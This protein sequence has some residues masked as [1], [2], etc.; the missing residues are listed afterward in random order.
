M[1]RL[2]FLTSA[3]VLITVGL[4]LLST[5]SG[6][7]PARAALADS[8]NDSKLDVTTC[9]ELFTELVNSS[10][11]YEIVPTG[12]TL[13]C[14]GVTQ[15]PI[16]GFT[17]SLDGNGATITDINI[18]CASNNCGIFESLVGT[19]SISNLTLVGPTIASTAALVGVVAGTA[20]TSS[21]TVS[22]D[23]VTV[24]NANVSGTLGVGGLVGGC[25]S[26]LLTSVAASGSVSGTGERVGGIA[27]SM[28]TSTTNYTNKISDSA[29]S[30][31]VSGSNYV[32][33]FVGKM[34]R[35]S[36][37]LSD[38][39]FRSIFSGSAT[40]SGTNGYIGG[41][42]G[43]TSG[44]G[45]AFENLISTGSVTGEELV[46]GIIGW[47]RSSA[48][49]I[50]RSYST[51][52]LTQTDPV[53]SSGAGG[54]VSNNDS[55]GKMTIEQSFSLASIVGACRTG[56]LVGQNRAEIIDSFFRGQLSRAAGSTD[57]TFG[58]VMGRGG[59]GSTVTRTYAAVSAPQS[60]GEGVSG[61]ASYPP[62]CTSTYWDK[63]T[64]TR[65]SSR[66]A[67]TGKT[68]AEMK[69]QTTF[70]NWDFTNVW[71]IDPNVNDGYPFLRNVGVSALPGGQNWTPP[72][73]TAPTV[74][75]TTATI[76]NTQNA[77][78]ESTETGTAYLID[79]TITV[80]QL[81]DIT[82][83]ADTAWNSTPI[84]N[85][86]TATNLAAT[87]LADGT[88]KAYAVDAAGNLSTVSTGTITIAA[89]TPTPAPAPNP[90]AITQ[91]STTTTPP[92]T[93]TPP[94]SP[95]I[96]PVAPQPPGEAT[97]LR[98]DGT[99][100]RAQVETQT[101]EERSTITIRNDDG[102]MLTVIHEPTVIRTAFN[103]YRGTRLAVSGDGYQPDTSVGVWLNSAPTYL[104]RTTTIGDGTFSFTVEIPGSFNL[105]Q[106]TL[107]IEG[108][109]PSDIVQSTFL[110][111]EVLE[112]LTD[113]ATPSLPRTGRDTDPVTGL[114]LI[115]LGLVAIY[116]SRRRHDVSGA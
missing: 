49:R 108:T 32:G 43:F 78:V 103:V 31:T 114:T 65:T 73:T 1:R 104:G 90:P 8:D 20:G 7:T 61:D 88:Y 15:A 82:G 36:P 48:E 2:A 50:Y 51:G 40:G 56:G 105:G 27:G 112:R 116:A 19:S 37:S 26:C 70:T 92:T 101:N 10:L 98:S 100:I 60:V 67:A 12:T 93:S 21:T 89:P 64:S 94:D 79:A 84:T 35:Q 99:E 17:G 47:S 24:S 41:F 110:G 97:S 5:T 59:N 42:V 63:E 13:S 57:T 86:N 14:T 102:T 16:V 30:A 80:S 77:V 69:T 9:A 4:S 87:G 91:P 18:S 81:S 54:I 3:T 58:G 75:L 23:A 83:A 113:S 39:I 74:T 34:D 29:S 71:A 53:C 52:V 6:E 72:D 115:A 55:F 44:G 107:Q 38:G 95:T 46:G 68:T 109:V 106:H 25:T 96:E 62:T 85:A 33:G 28:G 111:V 76:D 22:L 66:C 11:A 45:W